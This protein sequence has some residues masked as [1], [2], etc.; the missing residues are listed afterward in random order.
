M[1]PAEQQDTFNEL[2]AQHGGAENLSR[3][4]LETITA[5]VKA[6]EALRQAT[7]SDVPRLAG[8]LIKLTAQLPRGAAGDVDMSKLTADQYETLK[9]ADKIRSGEE[10]AGPP[11]PF[12]PDD[13]SNPRARFLQKIQDMVD[14][15]NHAYDLGDRSDPEDVA[16][17]ERDRALAE[18]ENLRA[19]LE[20]LLKLNA[21]LEERLAM[22]VTA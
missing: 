20:A 8:T 7:G 5:I 15:R 9:R 22:E 13:M 14:R 3:L 19:Q 10:P 11:K 21:L 4:Q 16:L 12:D 17:V 18:V 2:V 1:I 6:T